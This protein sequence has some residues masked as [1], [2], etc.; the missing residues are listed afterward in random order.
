[1][2]LLDAI[3]D[4]NRRRLAGDR[5]A[6]VPTADL[7]ASLPLAALTCIDARLNHLLPDML[8]LPEDEFIWLRNAGNIITGPLSST[9]RSLSL[10]CAVKGAKEI[11]IIGHSDCLVGKTTMMQL[12]DKLTALGVDR[13]RLPENLVEYFGLF[14]SERQNV[15]RGVELVRA[16]PLIGA[17]VPVHGLLIDVNTGQLDALVNGYEQHSVSMPGKA[18]ELFAKADKSLEM[19]GKVGEFA[20]DELKLP[21]EK[22]GEIVSTADSW[23]HKA[24]AIAA[25]HTP[26][27]QATADPAAGSAGK[28]PPRVQSAAA[29]PLAT[30][31]ERMRQ[32]SAQKQK[33]KSDQAH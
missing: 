9:M 22:I 13:Q 10:A 11:A 2:K 1:M 23:L 33:R 30:L 14:G 24:E 12:L 28:E 3:L 21:T 32:F 18:G 31:Q 16:S 27:K 19:L 25:A 7:A 6:T 8:G 20:H 4:A 17:R 29:N 26:A 5:Q 15:L